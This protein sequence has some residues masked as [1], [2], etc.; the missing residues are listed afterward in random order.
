[1]LLIANSHKIMHPLEVLAQ[2]TDQALQQHSCI[3]A[4]TTI[5]QVLKVERC[6]CMVVREHLIL[7]LTT[8]AIIR[9]VREVLYILTLNN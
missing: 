3:V 5:K 9:Q 4:C 7:I 1:M 2:S 8:S 6:M